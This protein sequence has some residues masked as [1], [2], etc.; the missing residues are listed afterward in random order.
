MKH[1]SNEKRKEKCIKKQEKYT[2]RLSNADE[3]IKGIDAAKNVSGGYRKKKHVRV[4]RK[5][6]RSLTG[7]RKHTRR[8]RHKR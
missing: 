3:R 1:N 8:V 5:K 2:K 7:R 6:R 4:T